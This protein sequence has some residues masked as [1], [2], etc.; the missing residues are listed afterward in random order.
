MGSGINVSNQGKVNPS[1]TVVSHGRDHT[2]TV[3]SV[4]GWKTFIAINIVQWGALGDSSQ[5]KG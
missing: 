4:N 3:G 2:N 1:Y 5:Q